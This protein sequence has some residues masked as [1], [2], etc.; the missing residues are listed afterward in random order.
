[1]NGSVVDRRLMRDGTLLGS[2]LLQASDHLLVADYQYEANVL[3]EKV[4]VLEQRLHDAI[5]LAA[6]DAAR[7]AK[8]YAS[9]EILVTY[10]EQ[11][12]RFESCLEDISARLIERVAHSLEITLS[13]AQVSEVLGNALLRE[14]GNSDF[15]RL[16]I[17]VNPSLYGAFET[18][19]NESCPKKM[20]EYV[21]VFSHESIP[22]NCL[23]V[24]ADSTVF[25]LQLQPI[26]SRLAINAAAEITNELRMAA[27][28]KPQ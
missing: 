9:S 28:G 12:Q 14:A 21:L 11:R 3:R 17:R 25:E 16:A 27:V 8:L 4:S 23:L 10:T 15:P 26:L 2:S 22:E 1:M 7:T 24:R 20:R 6:S 5:A 18:W 19:L 13:T